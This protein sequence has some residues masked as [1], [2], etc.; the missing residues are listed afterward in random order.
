MKIK[1]S[2]INYF[3]LRYKDYPLPLQ[4]RIYNSIPL[5][6][7]GLIASFLIIMLGFI[8]ANPYKDFSFYIILPSFFLFLINLFLIRLKKYDFA[9]YNVIIIII[10]IILYVFI[11]NLDYI[12]VTICLGGIIT[13][14][15]FYSKKLQLF[16]TIFFVAIAITSKSIFLFYNVLSN[17][18]SNYD[19]IPFIL[20][21]IISGIILNVWAITYKSFVNELAL[22]EKYKLEKE[23]AEKAN[24]A[25]NE[26]LSNVSHELKTPLN[27]IIGFSDI[28][29]EED[30]NEERKEMYK[31]I[32]GSSYKLLNIIENLLEISK[33]ESGKETNDKVKF[34]FITLV[35]TIEM[36]SKNMILKNDLTYNLIINEKIPQNLIGDRNKIEHILTNLIMN[37][38]KFTNKGEIKLKIDISEQIENNIVLKF[39]VID[40]GIG[41]PKDKQKFIFEKFVQG[42]YYLTK[43]YDGMGLGLSIC[44]S[45]VDILGGNIFFET[46]EGK[47]SIFSITIPL[48]IDNK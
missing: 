47:G 29:L 17:Q 11:K 28:L 7:S 9:I 2:V 48:E 5:T 6:F 23:R 12:L 41:I 18:N 16:I 24:Q 36:I 42:E 22:L 45:Y 26:F 1:Q 34:N 20:V 19:I 44:K 39:D 30:V 25:K 21:N 33:I 13:I 14:S 10:L 32:N 8:S 38:I 43:K 35:K 31:I 27:P 46:E 4:K 15:L 37:A 40:T 3:F